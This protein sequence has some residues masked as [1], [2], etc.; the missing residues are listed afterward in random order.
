MAM[1]IRVRI[2]AGVLTL[3]A[4]SGCEREPRTAAQTATGHQEHGAAEGDPKAHPAPEPGGQE[5]PERKILYW[6]DPM[7][8]QYRSD[9]PGVAPDCGMQ[10]VP[11]YADEVAAEDMP[12]GTVR[13]SPEKRQISG[14]R[15][16]L[17]QEKA[18]V[19]T[20]RTVGLLAADETQIRRVHTKISGWVEKVY[21]D[22]TGRLVEKGQPLVAIYSPELVSTQEEYLR[23]LQFRDA[24]KGSSFGHVRTGAESLVES[25]RTRL[26]YWDL[27]PRQ[28][29]E[30]EERGEPAKTVT[31]HSPI[32]GFVTAKQ[33]F[34]GQYVE[35]QM[36]LY[37]VTDLS[38]I[39]VYAYI[40]EYEMPFVRVGQE[41]A[42][43][44]S[45]YPGEVVRGKVTYVYPYLEQKTRTNKVRLE[46]ANAGYR[47]K[48][49]MYA[50]VELKVD[51]GDRLAVPEEAVL[52][53]GTEQVVFLAKGDGHFE[54]RRVRLGASAEGSLGILDG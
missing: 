37:T 44:L 39:W 27:T 12:A 10:L 48:P 50:D 16:G 53:S 20:I 54:P 40:Y 8:P 3:L 33:V 41:A 14:V 19:K 32:K 28:I 31:L 1:L 5:K 43:A 25:S 11:V 42:V 17:V 46:L 4:V 7:H 29:R 38:R 36:E 51:L 30:L 9:K 49:D 2:L 6:Q 18:L 21:V 23:A 34:E 35:P 45:Y 26:L 47:L 24:L 13:L 15:T 52:D 22:Y